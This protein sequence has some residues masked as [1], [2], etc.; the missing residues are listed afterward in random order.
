MSRAPAKGR[1]WTLGEH[2][3]WTVVLAFATAL[4]IAVLAACSTT[5]DPPR[6]THRQPTIP[7]VTANAE[8]AAACKGFAQDPAILPIHQTLEGYHPPEPILGDDVEAALVALSNLEAAA[9]QSGLDPDVA[10][11]LRQ[12]ATAGKAMHQEWQ[13]NDAPHFLD[14]KRFLRVVKRVHSVC[15]RAGVP[16]P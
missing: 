14:D 11:V 7:A 10:E 6:P 3:F 1:Q 5:I 12:A 4:A 9:A 2:F 15:E 8:T 16:M 13:A